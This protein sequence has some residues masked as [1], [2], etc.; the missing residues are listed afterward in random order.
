[1]GAVHKAKEKPDGNTRRIVLAIGTTIA[2]AVLLALTSQIS[3]STYMSSL[4][5]HRYRLMAAEIALFGILI[6]EMLGNMIL[7]KFRDRD[8]LQRGVAVRAIL[9]VVAYLVIGIA[10]VSM[11][12]A[13]PALAIGVGSVTGVVVAFAAQNILANVIAGM[14]VAVGR[15]F[16]IGDEITAAG[17]TGKVVEIGLTRTLVDAGDRWVMIPS[18][19]LVTGAVQ[20]TKRREAY[21]EVR[22]SE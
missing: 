3:T 19:L 11:L 20:R 15:P 5:P 10:S 18:M 7:K 8:A 1:M 4:T 22:E 13:N 21:D 6:V 17:A 9:R 2:F 12:A 14:F 16:S